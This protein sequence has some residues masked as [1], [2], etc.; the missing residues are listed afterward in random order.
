MF[1]VMHENMENYRTKQRDTISTKN[2]QST[3]VDAS[4]VIHILTSLPLVNSW[5]TTSAVITWLLLYGAHSGQLHSSLNNFISGPSI[6][7][8][9]TREV[10]VKLQGLTKCWRSES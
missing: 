1:V 2:C 8:R 4:N 7:D 5:Q 9:G 3:I 6:F 10:L